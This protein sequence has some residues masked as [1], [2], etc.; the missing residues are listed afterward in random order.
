MD[1]GGFFWW[2]FIFA[3]AAHL[4]TLPVLDFFLYHPGCVWI[5]PVNSHEDELVIAAHEGTSSPLLLPSL[6][7]ELWGLFFIHPYTKDSFILKRVL[8]DLRRLLDPQRG[9][10]LCFLVVHISWGHGNQARE[11]P[12]LPNAFSVL[13]TSG[14]PSSLGFWHNN[15]FLTFLW[16]FK[17]FTNSLSSIFSCVWLESFSS[18]L[19]HAIFGSESPGT[20]S[21]GTKGFTGINLLV[22]PVFLIAIWSSW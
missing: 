18:Y 9:C 6:G 3:L 17:D 20:N 15:F 14:F 8:W 11:W 16:C 1:D 22:I 4:G 19:A 7:P 10:R 21:T 5:W 12:G 13:F 2:G